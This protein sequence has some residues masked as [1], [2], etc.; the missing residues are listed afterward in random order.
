MPAWATAPFWF[1]AFGSGLGFLYELFLLIRRTPYQLLATPGGRFIQAIRLANLAPVFGSVYLAYGLLTLGHAGHAGWVIFLVGV[2]TGCLVVVLLF[3]GPQEVVASIVTT[4]QIALIVVLILSDGINGGWSVRLLLAVAS[5]GLY[6]TTIIGSQTPLRSTIFHVVATVVVMLLILGLRAEFDTA[7][8]GGIFGIGPRLLISLPIG[9]GL[10]F[11]LLPRTWA[12]FRSML[13]GLTWPFFYLFIAGGMRISRPERLGELYKGREDQLR[14]LRLLPYYIAHPRNLTHP[15]S[16]PCLDEALTLKVHS[17]GF[18]A[19]L[20]KFAFGAAS[21]VNKVFPI[22]NID[23]PLSQ[24]P[25]MDPW[26]DGSQ[27]WPRQFLKR[28]YIPRLGWFSIES[29][30]RGPGF[31]PTPQASIDAYQR[32]QLLA[33]LVEFGIAGTFVEPVIRSDKAALMMD[34]TFLEKYETKSDYE[35]YGGA[36]FFEIDDENRCLKLTHVRAP[37]AEK[38]LAVD[39]TDAIF[40]HA[41]D[42]ILATVYFLVVSGKHL[43]EIHMGLNLIEIALFNS[44][45]AK[46][47]WFHPVR[48]ALYPHLFAHELAEELTT[49]NLLEDKAV[50]PQIFATTNS[51]LMRHLNDRFR[52]YALAQDEDFDHRER[53]LLHGR[54]SKTLEQLLP[55]S[56]LVWEKRYA[57]IWMDYA[58][59]LV[60]AAYR[61][62]AEVA[63]DDCV[64]VLYANLVAMFRQPLPT[65]FAELKT[66]SGLARFIADMMHHLII[67]HEVYGTSGVRLALDPRINKVQVPRDGGAYGV[68][69]WRSLA[70]V[71]MATS[72]VRYTKLM[73]DFTNTFEDLRDADVRRQ[74]IDAHNQMKSQLEALESEFRSDGVENYDT[75]RL[76]PSDLDIGAGY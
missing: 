57:A 22:A 61:D 73:T 1:T 15:V 10:A 40:R 46:R 54:E 32:G 5:I 45:D 18:L 16:V 47:E 62:D 25:R 9:A 59:K 24:K 65:R 67:R 30:V 36:A 11:Y 31:Q 26:S 38:E 55:R 39:P 6:S 71:A 42:M 7:L 12:V 2:V 27:Y 28:I 19:R 8:H 69:E 14:P 43:V 23:V 48:L 75:L 20:V 13:S 64:Q 74:F 72:R 41:E 50:F 44:F 34:L 29:G 58:N 68:D 76:L 3:Q 33:F 52:E 56:S 51:S 53:V 66:R 4:G 60:E 70:C 21:L 37:L 17:L 63:A 49:Q 35:A